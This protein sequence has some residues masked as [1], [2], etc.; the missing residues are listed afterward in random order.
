MSLASL[1][2]CPI[3]V[4]SDGPSPSKARALL[5]ARGIAL[6]GPSR[7]GGMKVW[8]AYSERGQTNPA[9]IRLTQSGD[10]FSVV[11]V[12]ARAANVTFFSTEEKSPA[13]GDESALK[14]SM[15]AAA[16]LFL[17]V[18]GEVLERGYYHWNGTKIAT[19]R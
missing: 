10:K 6:D 12:Q 3:L 16:D 14:R 11:V 17:D 8:S 1:L 19:G 18:N 5:K 2:A 9:V 4:E 15:D 13:V 7:D